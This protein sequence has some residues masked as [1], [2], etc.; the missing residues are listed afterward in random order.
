MT[1]FVLIALAA[2]ML[3][4]NEWLYAR[5]GIGAAFAGLGLALFLLFVSARI[6]FP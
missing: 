3:P 5:F 2:A 1:P 4:I 6:A